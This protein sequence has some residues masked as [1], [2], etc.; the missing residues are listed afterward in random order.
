VFSRSVSLILLALVAASVSASGYNRKDW[1]HWEDLDGDCQNTRAEILIRDSRIPV[2]FKDRRECSVVAG[3]WF[4]PYTGQ[5]FY[6]AS[7]V[8]IDHVVPL[9]HAHRA[10]GAGWSRAQKLHFAND[11]DNLLAVD[12]QTNQDKG[13]K[14]P[15]QWMPP[16]RD[17]WCEYLEKW[18]RIEVRYALVPDVVP[19]VSCP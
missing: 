16:R 18:Q 6:R 13:A 8:D 12:D 4:G 14:P 11:P 3:E 5:T 17:Y 2:Q 9:A 19:L 10:G 15:S 7:D 1:P